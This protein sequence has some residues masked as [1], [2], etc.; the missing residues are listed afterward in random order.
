MTFKMQFYFAIWNQTT[1][2]TFYVSVC[3]LVTVVTPRMTCPRSEHVTVLAIYTLLSKVFVFWPIQ[4][5][6][7]IVFQLLSSFTCISFINMFHYQVHNTAPLVHIVSQIN[8]VNDSPS[9]FFKT[10]LNVILHLRL[11]L[12]NSLVPSVFPTKISWWCNKKILLLF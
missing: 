6:Y 2:C 11:G 5:L 10:K 9:Y 12:L 4:I 8:Q 1:I 7:I 3:V